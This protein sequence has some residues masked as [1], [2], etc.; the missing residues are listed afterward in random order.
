MKLDEDLL[1]WAPTFGACLGKTKDVTGRIVV[2]D[3]SGHVFLRLFFMPSNASLTISSVNP[4]VQGISTMV[5][6][7]NPPYIA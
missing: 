4:G 3:L 1:I 7:G 5:G 6:S 2:N